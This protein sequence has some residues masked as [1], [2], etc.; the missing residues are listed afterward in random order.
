LLTGYEVDGVAQ[1]IV[2]T[3]PFSGGGDA[4]VYVTFDGVAAYE[5]ENDL[6]ENMVFEIEEGSLTETQEIANRIQAE[7]GRWGFPSR[8]EL[9]TRDGVGMLHATEWSF[10]WA[11][12]TA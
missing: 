10:S 12:H 8:V 1:R 5:F 3:Q 4:F 6:L 11:V 7:E 9:E 2:H